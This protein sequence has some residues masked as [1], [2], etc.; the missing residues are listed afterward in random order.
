MYNRYVPQPDGSYRRNQ[1]PDPKKKEAPHSKKEQPSYE[2][3][4]TTPQQEH[5]SP[6]C[7]QEGSISSFFRQI[8][9]KNLDT[10]DLLVILLL[11]LMAS[12]CAEEQNTAMLT[13]ALYL[14]L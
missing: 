1:M 9:P 4:D 5:K 3:C 11:L 8:L 12:D 10:G 6:P 14:F 13:L 2:S 7:R